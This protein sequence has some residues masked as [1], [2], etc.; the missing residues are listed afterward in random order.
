MAP[1]IVFRFRLFSFV[2]GH[3][4]YGPAGFPNIGL[5]YRIVFL[6]TKLNGVGFRMDAY[7]GQE[8]ITKDPNALCLSN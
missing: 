6:E 5:E 4:Q 2:A 1:A 7:I 3:R 8:A